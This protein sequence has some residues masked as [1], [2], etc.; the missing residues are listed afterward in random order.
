MTTRQPISLLMVA[1]LVAPAVARAEWGAKSRACPRW[2]AALAQ[3]EQAGQTDSQRYRRLRN[4]IADRCVAMNE[5]QVLG[6]HNSYHVQPRPPLLAFF[7]AASSIFG[8]WEYTH[9]PL[10]VQ[11]ETEGIRQVEIDVSTPTR[12]AGSSRAAAAWC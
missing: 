11:L 12:R 2:T 3:L 1:V 9:P 5:V 4:R 6:T 8:E 7:L 10:D